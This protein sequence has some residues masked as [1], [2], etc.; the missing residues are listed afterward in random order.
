M[1]L[2][3]EID[4]LLSHFGDDE[5][6]LF[7]R[8]MMTSKS[9]GQ[10][11][12]YSKDE[13]LKRCLESDF[14][15][16]RINAYPEYTKWEKYDLIR[17]P[18]SFIFIDLDLFN[19]SK[20]KDPKKTLDGVLKNTLKR[21]MVCGN[22]HSQRSRD[23]HSNYPHQQQHRNVRPIHPTVLWTGNG[24][25]VY[26]PMQSVVLDAYE[27]FSKDK[28]PNLFSM[29]DC[30][31]NGYSVSEVFLKFAEQYFTDGKADPQHKP[32]FKS[33]LIRFP[34]TYNSKCLA[35]GKSHEESKVKL[36]QEW[37]GYRLPIQYLTKEFRRWLVQKEID[38][39][40]I[41]IKKIQSN[42]SQ[43]KLSY[44]FDYID[45]IERLLKTPIADYRKYCLW[46]ILIPYLKNIKKLQD[47]EIMAILLKWLD[48]CNRYEKL[49][50]DPYQKIKE[51][52]RNV[53]DYKP[54]GLERL[55]ETNA[56][57]YALSVN[58]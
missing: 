46:Q 17:Q 23:H 55:K 24:Y 6:S 57:L 5:K 43:L 26:L 2:E 40:A 12:V 1:N 29:Y 45:W 3:K 38:Q 56:E 10:F 35:N 47:E 30:K 27:Q 48:G 28:F 51:N 7:P 8:K 19:F 53:K 14:I 44:L 52:L 15:D 22:E 13:I 33:C 37:D 42:K 36:I 18:P 9:N 41:N 20:Y 54:I 58:I 34:N 32:K 49:D 50:F 31:Y 16:C 21:M 25:H 39:V 11:T 4:F